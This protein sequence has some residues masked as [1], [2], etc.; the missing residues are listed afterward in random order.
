MQSACLVQCSFF[1]APAP[2]LL[3]PVQRVGFLY[4]RFEEYTEVPLGIRA[5]VVAIYE[6]PQI[7]S[8]LE[9]ELMEDQEEETAVGMVA[10]HLG[11]QK[12][13]SAL[14]V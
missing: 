7:S 9:V 12:V 10:K 6:P 3:L 4:G 13:V 1:P 8:L 11:L 5:V 14:C 2:C